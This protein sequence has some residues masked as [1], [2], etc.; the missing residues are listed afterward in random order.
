[1][2]NDIE[3]SRSYYSGFPKNVIPLL[4]ISISLFL[5]NYNRVKIGITND[6]ERRW[7]DHLR[8]DAETWDRMVIKYCTTSVNNAN[9]IEKYFIDTEPALHNFGQAGAIWLKQNTITS[10]FC[11]VVAK[12][13]RRWQ[14]YKKNSICL[15]LA[16]QFSFFAAFRITGRE[17][18]IYY[19]IVLFTIAS[20]SA[21]L[22][23]TPTT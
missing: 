14:R 13:K 4:R 16:K 5:R 7:R 2:Q 22:A 11:S 23:M 6:P 9:R 20:K 1:M 8:Q 3:Y 19:V 17:S 12:G 15:K 10:T 18:V 21:E